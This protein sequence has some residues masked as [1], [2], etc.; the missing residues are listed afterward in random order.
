M[1]GRSNVHAFV[2]GTHQICLLM[3]YLSVPFFVDL[4]GSRHTYNLHPVTVYQCGAEIAFRMRVRA[5]IKSGVGDDTF[6]AYK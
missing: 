5:E 2:V 3:I 1:T 6:C 4:G